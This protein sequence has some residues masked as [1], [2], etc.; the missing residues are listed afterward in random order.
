MRIVKVWDS[1][2]PWD[3]R[4]EKVMKT[5]SENGHSVSL[6]CRNLKCMP[7]FEAMGTIRIFRLP[8]TRNKWLNRFISFPYFFNF[9]WLKT[10]YSTCQKVD[11][12][13]IIVRDLPLALTTITVG[14]W[15]KI[16]VI[17][18]MA[19]NY[20]AML[21]GRKYYG[22]FQ[23]YQ[24]L[25]R[26]GQLA[27]LVEYWTLKYTNKIIVVAEENK[28][29]LIAKG[30][31]PADIYLVSNTPDL[32]LIQNLRKNLPDDEGRYFSDRFTLI[33]VGLL[34]SIRGLE[35]VVRAM[36]EIIGRIPKVHL[37]VIGRGMTKD[38]LVKLVIEKGLREYVTFKDW[39]NFPD[40]PR[41]LKVVKAGLI[42]HLSTEHTNTTIP[43][44][45]F[46]Y[47]AHGL[48]VIGSD[49]APIRRIIQE[50]MCGVTFEAN[51]LN[52]FVNAVVEVYRDQQNHFGKNGK[53]AVFEKY[54]WKEDSAI[55][56]KL[57]TDL[58][59]TNLEK[60]FSTSSASTL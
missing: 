2:Y 22:K 35:M 17:L 6:V 48:P 32:D 52:D 43:N 12:Q 15:L 31:S 47:M 10:I 41:Y 26:N 46:D 58:Q 29:R 49:V 7:T 20:P 59:E 57:F 3:I 36:P 54:N 23:F 21:R 24:K 40:I 45:I 28:K 14:R 27:E 60:A 51:N 55:L 13:A 5:L 53:R 38:V 4:V 19:E 9:L 30:V 25:L 37:L 8:W 1:D 44:K 34:G 11:A 16:P 18:D 42:P 39:I 33:Y 50:E 56:L